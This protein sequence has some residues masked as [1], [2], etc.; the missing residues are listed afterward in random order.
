MPDSRKHRGPHPQDLSIFADDVAPVLETAARDYSWLLSREYPPDASLKL[1]GDRFGLVARQRLAVRRAS[2]SAAQALAR[3]AKQLQPP[4]VSRRTLEIDGFN[5]LTTVEAAMA[6]GMILE[7][8]DGCWRDM[9]SMHGTY[10][11]VEETI[12]AITLTG[13]TLERLEVEHCRWLIDQPVSNSGRLR[14]M[15]LEVAAEKNWNWSVDVVRD[16]DPL[17][18][19]CE[20]IV[21]SADSAILNKCKQWFNL[22]KSVL[23][24]LRDQWWIVTL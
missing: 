24:P 14:A 17:L 16:P 9:A 4:E 11:R 21:C 15:L 20:N 23:A 7:S 2:C 19:A 3:S 6:G 13:E 18:A 12:P 10:R 8:Q 1:V 5:L 22:A